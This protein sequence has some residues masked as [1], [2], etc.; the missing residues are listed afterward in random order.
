MLTLA[1]TLNLSATTIAGLHGDVQREARRVRSA[2]K[3]K[4][5]DERGLC[6]PS[7]DSKSPSA[8]EATADSALTRIVQTRD[9]P[10]VEATHHRDAR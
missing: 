3:E 10:V 4:G 6:C 1:D 9:N 8:A 5:P 2:S 7:S